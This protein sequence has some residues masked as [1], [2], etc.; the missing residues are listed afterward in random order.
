MG[1]LTVKVP[2]FFTGISQSG[3][4]EVTRLLKL[5][6]IDLNPPTPG[7]FPI[8]FPDRVAFSY[9]ICGTNE[10]FSGC[11]CNKIDCENNRQ[12]IIAVSYTHLRAHETDSY[13]V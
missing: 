6:L 2:S 13:L 10:R 3:L 4:S 8:I 5:R 12:T 9:F 7:D 1:I 11:A